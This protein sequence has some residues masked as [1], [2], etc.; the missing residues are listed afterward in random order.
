MC[1]VQIIGD[2][3][4]RLHLAGKSPI[5]SAAGPLA[6]TGMPTRVAFVLICRQLQR[7]VISKAMYG[8]WEA[9][10]AYFIAVAMEASRMSTLTSA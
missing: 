7:L 4:E 6:A 2:G 5:E 9:T 3:N 1:Q 10:L 8:L